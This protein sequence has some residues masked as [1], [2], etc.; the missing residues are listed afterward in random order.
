MTVQV[1][2]IYL[3]SEPATAEVIRVSVGPQGVQG[4]QGETG[5]QGPQ[6]VQGPQ[7]EPGADGLT[8]LNGTT[9]PASGLG[10]DGDFY[11]RT[12]NW[13]IYGPKAAG[14]WPAAQSLVG[15]AGQQGDQGEPGPQG[16]PGPAG[17][18]GLTGAAG[19]SAYEVAVANGFEGDEAAWLASLEGPAGPAGADG[20]PGAAGADGAPGAAGAAGA[21]GA[22]GASAYEVAVANGFVGDEAAWL[23]SLVGPAGADGAPGADGADG[24]PGAPGE[25]S[26]VD[27]LQ[28]G[29]SVATDVA[30]LDFRASHFTAT[31]NTDGSVTISLVSVGGGDTTIVFQTNVTDFKDSVQAAT[32]TNINVANPGTAIFDGVTLTAGQ[33]LLLFG[34]TN[35]AQ[36]GIYDF[37]GSGVALTRSADADADDE[38]TSG[39]LVLV[40]DGGT[41]N[42]SKL[43]SLVTADPITVGTTLLTF[44]SI[45]LPS[46]PDV[47]K[48]VTAASY[49]LI[50][51]DPNRMLK[52]NR[53]TAQTFTL[54]GPSVKVPVNSVL[55]IWQYGAGAITVAPG[56][57][58][59]IRAPQGLSTNRQYALMRIKKTAN[60]EWLV[61]ITGN[62]DVLTDGTMAANS[63]TQPPSQSAVITYV[64]AAISALRNGVSSAFD[65]LAEIA[66]E[67]ALKSTIA[68]PTF[69]G[70]PAAPTAAPGTNTTQI[71]T[72][73][74]V[75]A[76]VDVVL[77]G[78]S[79][80]FDTLSEIATELALAVKKGATANL[81]AGY[82]ATAYNAG[83]KSSGTFT[84]D[85]ANGNL[86][87][88]VN[89]GAHTLAPPSVGTGDALTMVIQYTNNGSA[90]A[91]T[92]SG[93][94]K[95]DG[96]FTTTN[97]DDFMCYISVV[98]GFSHLSIVAL[99]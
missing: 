29:A 50:A 48:E 12:S 6:G 95:V 65:T 2:K 39:M 81:T 23:A 8:I 53:A 57:G 7:G 96:S 10:V 60:G 52:G 44:E 27:V 85:P 80:A 35:K 87:R 61:T 1:I 43:F 97:G 64:A 41:D 70:T 79:S 5:A 59:T 21:D 83:T 94:N 9:A 30:A 16:D 24:A 11:V 78:V 66:T 86:Q 34:Q 15:P 99:Q 69:T 17:E 32:A 74:F 28:D 62:T 54:P 22:D 92:T 31:P 26:A 76:A 58:A 73:A 67:L 18:S 63:T 98:N 13:T 46:N 84:P 3:P 20:A 90:G 36:N 89:G 51:T 42:G 45:V 33:R 71:A 25:A 47:I 55:Y 38:V 88:A 75:K 77:G 91:I 19:A 49:T 14:A 56:S 82:T 93:F 4:I 40:E 37:N 68:S 72:T